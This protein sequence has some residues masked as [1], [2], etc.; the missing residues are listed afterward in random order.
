MK[1]AKKTCAGG[2]VLACSIPVAT[3]LPPQKW[4]AAGLASKKMT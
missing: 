4:K 3:P 1:Y 2:G